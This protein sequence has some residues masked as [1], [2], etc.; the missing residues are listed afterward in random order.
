VDPNKV[1]AGI[2]NGMLTVVAPIA[3]EAKSRKVS[4]HAA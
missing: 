2:K 1:K 4:V 3:E